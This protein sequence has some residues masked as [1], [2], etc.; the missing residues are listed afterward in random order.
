MFIPLSS[1]RPIFGSVLCSILFSP[2]TISQIGSESSTSAR[3]G[4][5]A[6]DAPAFSLIS[7]GQQTPM[8]L[9]RFSLIYFNK[10][11][12]HYEKTKIIV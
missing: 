8:A 1:G 9:L 3:C 5:D 6:I 10:K 11:K 12:K 2:E 4:K 7:S